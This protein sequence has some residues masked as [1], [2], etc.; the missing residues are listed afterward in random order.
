MRTI[1]N[2]VNFGGLEQLE[3]RDTVFAGTFQSRFGE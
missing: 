1:V 2:I 3:H